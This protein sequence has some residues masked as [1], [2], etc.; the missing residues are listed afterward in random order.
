MQFVGVADPVIRPDEQ[1]GCENNAP[2][3]APRGRPGRRPLAARGGPDA[4]LG[5]ML[6]LYAV[7][8]RR[9]QTGR[10]SP[11]SRRRIMCIATLAERSRTSL[12]LPGSFGSRARTFPS[13]S[14]TQMQT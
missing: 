4:L 12:R 5:P 10:S 7:P 3:L 11:I 9:P 2:N 13:A 8:E 14:T 6:E 1:V